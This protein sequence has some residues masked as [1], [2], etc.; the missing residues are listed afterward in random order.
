MKRTSWCPVPEMLLCQSY[1]RS[2]IYYS[3]ILYGNVCKTR[4]EKNNIIQNKALKMFIRAMNSTPAVPFR[5]ES[6]EPALCI[7]RK[8][9]KYIA[10]LNLKSYDHPKIKF[11]HLL[12]NIGISNNI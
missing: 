7:K 4:S 3:S 8:C 6:N 1:I 10:T 11:M 9:D 12:T 5:F 2:K